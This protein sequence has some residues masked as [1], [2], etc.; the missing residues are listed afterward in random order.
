MD[1]I[2]E[3]EDYEESI[4][5]IISEP[6]PRKETKQLNQTSDLLYTPQFKDRKIE[7]IAEIHGLKQRFRI[8]QEQKVNQ[9][10]KLVSNNELQL[11]KSQINYSLLNKQSIDLINALVEEE[12]DCKSL[13]EKQVTLERQISNEITKRENFAS[14][15]KI[16]EDTIDLSNIPIDPIN[17]SSVQVSSLE[18]LPLQISFLQAKYDNLKSELAHIDKEYDE[19]KPTSQLLQ[20]ISKSYNAKWRLEVLG[21]NYVNNDIAEMKERI[22]SLEKSISQLEKSA[23][24]KRQRVVSSKG[25]FQAKY[26]TLVDNVNNN[27]KYFNEQLSILDSKKISVENEINSLSQSIKSV[28][29]EIEHMNQS[30]IQNFQPQPDESEISIPEVISAK[31]DDQGDSYSILENSLR[32]HKYQL[33]N[34]IDELKNGYFKTKSSYMSSIEHKK[35]QIS[36]LNAKYSQVKKELKELKEIQL[37]QSSIDI[38]SIQAN[39]DRNLNGLLELASLNSLAI[40]EE[41]LNN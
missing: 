31:P 21:L 32:N 41:I 37:E 17:I 16:I 8:L 23:S 26:A 18:N 7:I 9:A 5:E 36:K 39:V 19:K 4:S 22:S 11:F 28:S 12:R 27:I 35:R 15:T 2:G 34:Q 25:D 30:L 38:S 24:E 10:Q 3:E 13:I 6:T 14:D 29:Q 33:I 40:P 1:S 20:E